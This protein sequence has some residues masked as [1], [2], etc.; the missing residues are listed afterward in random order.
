MT[1]SKVEK[2]IDGDTI[3]ADLNL[4]L[5]VILDDQHISLYGIDTQREPSIV[6]VNETI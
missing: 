1:R 2:L 4:C 3:I 6:S 5:G